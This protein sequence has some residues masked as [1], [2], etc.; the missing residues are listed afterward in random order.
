MAQ[1]LPRSGVG[2]KSYAFVGARPSGYRAGMVRRQV[3][4][5]LATGLLSA[6]LWR[7]YESI[8]EVHLTVLRQMTDKL[9]GMAESGHAPTA[10]NMVEFAYP[11]QRGRDFLRAFR[12]SAQRPS[13]QAFAEL[14]DHYEAMLKRIDAARLDEAAWRAQPPLLLHDR[15]V[16]DDL[17]ARIRRDLAHQ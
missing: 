17:A 13:Y 10:A 14:L 11:A 6:C 9:S 15:G 5:V 4:V 2:L 1:L 3:A 7:S 8:L 12:S 16:L